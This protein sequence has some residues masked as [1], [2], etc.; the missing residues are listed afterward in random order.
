MLDSTKIGPPLR[1]V[2]T[3]RP[4]EFIMNMLLNTDQMEKKD[5]EVK[6]MISQYGTFMTVQS[7]TQDQARALLE[8]LRQAATQAPSNQ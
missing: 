7:L 3:Q 4:P 6:K 8:F 1:P 2:T 5:P